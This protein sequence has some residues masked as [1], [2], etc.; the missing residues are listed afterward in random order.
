MGWLLGALLLGALVSGGSDES[1][2]SRA[3]EAPKP[4]VVST[5]GNVTIHYSQ[6][7]GIQGTK[8]NSGND[9]SRYNISVSNSS[10]MI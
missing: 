5:A 4:P 1:S 3:Q 6:A 8:N 9:W 2:A 10:G 7:S